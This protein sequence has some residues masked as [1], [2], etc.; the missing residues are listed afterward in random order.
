LQAQRIFK[1]VLDAELNQSEEDPS[2]KPESITPPVSAKIKLM[3]SHQKKTSNSFHAGGPTP[4]GN[5]FSLILKITTS[6]AAQT[7][8]THS[9]LSRTPR[10]KG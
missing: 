1:E 10:N 5:T 4:D 2:I 7:E 8:L 3:V 9:D 6:L